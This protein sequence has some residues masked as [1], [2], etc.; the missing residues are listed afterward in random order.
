VDDIATTFRRWAQ[1]EAHG[2]SAT[3]E[4]LAYAMAGRGD[5]TQLLQSVPRPKRQPNLLFGV[6][7]WYGVDVTDPDVAVQWALDHSDLVTEALSQRRTQTNEAARTA[8]LLPALA[9][10]PGPLA[11]IEVGA[12]AGLCLLYDAYRYHYVGPGVDHTIGD[13]ASPVTL[14]CE[15]DGPV[16]LPAAVPEIVFRA[17]L[18]LNPVDAADP[19]ARRWLQCLV[20]PEHVDRAERL[21]AALDI[22]ATARPQIHEGDLITELPRLLDQLPPGATPVVVHSATLAY[23][24]E[25]QRRGFIEL[26]ADRAVHRVG[27]E[28]LDVLPHLAGRPAQHDTAWRFVLSLDDQAVGLAQPHGRRLTWLNRWPVCSRR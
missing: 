10:L 14:T 13:L 11:I 7:R 3:Y 17:G 15:V 24:D 26:L 20:W 28:G 25:A 27:A 16:P 23:L 4:R 1:R 9:L 22:A 12:S 8:T 19:D 5:V 21:T 6:L 2:S 18:D